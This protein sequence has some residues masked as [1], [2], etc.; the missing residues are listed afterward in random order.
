M[1]TSRQVA[2]PGLGGLVRRA[3]VS[4]GLGGLDPHLLT[5]NVVGGGGGLQME[6][7][8]ETRYKLS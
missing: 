7:G 5:R 4:S 3:D 2:P 8:R 6:Q 1:R